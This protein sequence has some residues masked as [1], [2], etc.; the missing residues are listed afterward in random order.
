MRVASPALLRIP[1]ASVHPVRSREPSPPPAALRPA[2]SIALPPAARQV[3]SRPTVV[4]LSSIGGCTTLAFDPASGG[5]A[6]VFALGC[7][8]TFVRTY[9]LRTTLGGRNSPT[10]GGAAGALPL[11]AFAPRR[12]LEAAP[13]LLDCEHLSQG[14]SGLAY[15]ER[16]ELLVN[17]RGANL[18]LFDA[19]DGA[20][21][22]LDGPV[23][24]GGVPTV[25]S[26]LAEYH[27]RVN[28]ET[29][30]KEC[31]FVNGGQHVASGGDCGNIFLWDK[32][33]GALLHTQRA[34]GCI[35]NC[36]A[37]HPSLPL[38]A[39]SGIDSDVKL[40][41]LGDAQDCRSR[42]GAT[43]LRA[44][45]GAADGAHFARPS[46]RPRVR[47][48]RQHGLDRHEV[49][50]AEEAEVHLISAREMLQ[51][52]N[53]RFGAGQHEAAREAYEEAL[54]ALSFHV[55]AARACANQ[56]QSRLLCRLNLAACLLALRLWAGADKAC[57]HVLEVDPRNV[58]ALYRRAQ[59]LI[60]LRRLARAELDVTAA[61][62]LRPG[63]KLL[64][65]LR[66][67]LLRKQGAVHRGRMADA[68]RDAARALLDRLHED[69]DTQKHRAVDGS[70]DESE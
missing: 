28:Q 67:R 4:D 43:P 42:N 69:G 68:R 8:D 37:P 50:T 52:G 1:W 38:L 59:A 40:F 39:T 25:T 48:R 55:A 36:V 41:S 31:A 7:A 27:G 66:Q 63:D 30:A 3:T 62:K 61:L 5:G 34:D 10:G 46:L 24:D 32:R 14:A 33:T 16:G 70:G 57:S 29:F 18:Y 19:R 60:G 13:S 11:R 51:R 35:V 44:A 9:D 12:L 15:S 20:P 53:E 22:A 56:A 6:N 47:P 45:D 21:S 64:E 54:V 49:L 23:H 65:D 17:L 2:I 26:I 58:K